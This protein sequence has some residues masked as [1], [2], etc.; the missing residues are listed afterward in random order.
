MKQF[1]ENIS[2]PSDIGESFPLGSTIFQA[3][4][5]F[6]LFCKNRTNVEL[7]LFD[8]IDDIVPSKVITLHARK[9]RTYHYWHV[10]VPGISNG[11]LYAYRI[12]R[13][14]EPS[15]GHRF[16][17]TQILLDP[18]AHAV[19]VPQGY[20][21]SSIKAAENKSTPAMK[22]VVADLSPYDW[23]GD[24]PLRR[25]FRKTVIYEM[26]VAGFTLDPGS[27]VEASKRGTY[28]G[29]IEKIPYLVDL[30]ITAVELLP[31]FQFDEQD[32]PAGLVNYWGYCPVS[33][34]APH[35]GY[36]S[37]RKPLHVLD[38]FRDMVKALHAAGIEVVLDVTL[39]R[40]RG[41]HPQPTEFVSDSEGIIRRSLEAVRLTI[42]AVVP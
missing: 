30:G 28:S 11:Q 41:R 24:M 4:V 36:S 32:C 13:P 1:Q 12:H 9:N 26:H 18:Y 39:R 6:S 37:S 5:N 23:E 40:V 14:F 17:A 8:D 35:Q 38:E 16:D 2:Q 22:S 7:L 34:F 15:Q 21:R 42:I 10:F 25:P 29:L 3:G 33:F 19:A 31:V 20:K 27:N